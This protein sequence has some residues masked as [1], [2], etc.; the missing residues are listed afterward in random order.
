MSAELTAQNRAVASVLRGLNADDTLVDMVVPLIQA[1]QVLIS[2]GEVSRK[3]GGFAGRLW[4]S[5][6]DE[7]SNA[8]I[9]RSEVLSPS[10]TPP[11]R[12]S[13]HDDVSDDMV[14]SALK[15][16]RDDPN[17][18]EKLEDAVVYY[19]EDSHREF[20]A[21]AQSAVDYKDFVQCVVEEYYEAIDDKLRSLGHDTVSDDRAADV[22]G[23]VL[24]NN[25]FHDHL[26]E[27]VVLAVRT[28]ASRWFQ[29]LEGDERESEIN[30]ARD[31]LTPHVMGHV[32]DA[33]REKQQSIEIKP[34]GQN[35]EQK[36]EGLTR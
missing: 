19:G 16:I 28:E 3:G 22:I 9:D 21:A 18:R 10:E 30:A 6:V 13:R 36:S 1:Y 17:I 33:L 12:K 25:D 20:N 7:H 8:V 23:E 31:T 11:D 2:E 15:Y 26:E 24:A 4:R 14:V 5:L 29:H 35:V 27:F 32:T 34:Q